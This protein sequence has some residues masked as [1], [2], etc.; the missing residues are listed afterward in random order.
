MSYYM[1]YWG[2]SVQCH[3]GDLATSARFMVLQG[4]RKQFHSGSPGPV[5]WE[6]YSALTDIQSGRAKD[7]FGWVHEI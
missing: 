2:L 7:E 3:G 5:A 4:K 6:L 1:V